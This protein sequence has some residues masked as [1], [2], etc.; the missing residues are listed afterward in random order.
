MFDIRFASDTKELEALYRFRYQIYVEE[1]DRVQHHANHQQRW[2]TDDLDK[3][4][5]NLVAYSHRSNELVGAV[6]ANFTRDGAIPYYEEFFRVH[7]QAGATVENTSICTRMM[8]AN[9]LRRSALAV[10]LFVAI[11]EFGLWNGIRYNFIDC[12]DHL[13]KLFE[14]FG[15]RHYMG[16]AVHKEYGEV[17]PLKL[18]LH[19]EEFFREICS[20]FLN[21]YLEWKGSS[22]KSIYK[23]VE[24]FLPRR[25]GV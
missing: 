19:D 1:M 21:P 7:D 8:I 13:V 16:T 2:I 5:K 9:S 15:F 25:E 6:R 23:S 17:H 4:G 3:T 10:R 18:D 22:R 24:S 12:N 20:P 11:Y 14:S